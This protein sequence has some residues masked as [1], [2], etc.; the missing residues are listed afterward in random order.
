MAKLSFYSILATIPALLAATTIYNVDMSF[1]LFDRSHTFS[2]AEIT[3]VTTCLL[4]KNQTKVAVDLVSSSD[5]NSY[6][7]WYDAPTPETSIV[8]KDISKALIE[9]FKLAR[10]Q[11][12]YETEPYGG[13]AVLGT[14]DDEVELQEHFA[15][16]NSEYPEDFEFHD[17]D[18][19]SMDGNYFNNTDALIHTQNWL[20]TTN[21]YNTWW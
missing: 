8:D 11:D 3:N 14:W 9:C 6:T 7:I 18:Y 10:P 21:H 16:F 5:T 2:D 4:S 12:D 20:Y 17:S 1:P 13:Y 15:Y 19:D